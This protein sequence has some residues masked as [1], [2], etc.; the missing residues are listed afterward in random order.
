[1]EKKVE[2]EKDP[3]LRVE[4]LKKYYP[5]KGGIITHKIGDVKA[6]NGVSFSL[7]AGETLGL[8]ESRAAEN[9]L[10]AARSWDWNGRRPGKFF[11]REWILARCGQRT[12]L[13]CG[14]S[15]RWC[16]RIHFPP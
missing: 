7:N 9:P 5:V 8:V 3:I 6:V 15:F 1:M 12:W 11:I 13:R 14:P 2:N 10:S 4:D 16:F